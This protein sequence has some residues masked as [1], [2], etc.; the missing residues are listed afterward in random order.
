[1]LGVE[2][3][4]LLRES[5]AQVTAVGRVDLDVTEPAAVSAA[6]RGHD[7]VLNCAAWTDVD[8]AEQNEAAAV[9][10]NGE[11]AALLAGA[12]REAGARF[13][14]ISTDYVFA[15]TA[16]EPYAEEASPDPRSAYG[17]S[18]ALGEKLARREHPAGVLVVRTA[19]LYG[20]HGRC[21][22]RAIARLARERGGVDVVEDQVGQP[23]WARDVAG[24]VH[25]LVAADAPAGTYHATSSGQ[26]SWFDFAQ[27]IVASAGMEP[28]VVRPVSSARF[29]RPAPRPAYSV[30][31]HEALHRLGIA[32]IGDWR[33]R[34]RAAAQG[35]LS[36][37][38]R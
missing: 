16:S 25:R 8:G 10:V 32:P 26:G 9:A 3:V 6:V 11:A 38:S 2:A 30:L 4:A 19:W 21:F 1:M 12:A 33:E 27:E 24:L 22:P 35:V 13:V 7:V 14:Q 36:S 5:G 20:A 18:K 31:G 37:P 17:R 29:P 15:G 34:W 28:S 23:T